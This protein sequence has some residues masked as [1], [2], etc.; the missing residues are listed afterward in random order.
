MRRRLA[1]LAAVP[2]LFAAACGSSGGD[3]SGTAAS[4]AASSASAAANGAPGSLTVA[5]KTGAKPTVTFTA[6]RPANTS[7]SKVLDEGKGGAVKMGD[8]VVANMTVYT[9]DGKTNA[10]GGSTYDNGAPEVV[11][12]TDQLPKVVRD[13]FVATKPGGRFYAVV[14]AD[15][16]TKEQLDE[17]KKQGAD[18]SVAQV[19]VVDVLGA[20]QAKTAS[21][22]DTGATVKGVQ[23]E[24]PGEGQA[25]K[26]TTKT[27]DK[28]STKLVAETV[29]KGTGPE[30]KSGEFIMVQ[31]VGKIWGTDS[32]FDSSWSR[33]GVPVLFQIGAGKVI[34]GWDEGLV[35]IPVGSRVLL[36]IPPDLGYGSA[37]QGDKIKG[38][39]TLV[40]AVD[41]L[42][43]F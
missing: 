13:G 28:A 4:P 37:G 31:Y 26:L 19:F 1:V 34:K 23:L 11:P 41:V 32:E 10:T 22:K 42:G 6:G 12:L 29:I 36:T 3:G 15:N 16:Y 30:V 7:T 18:T 14:A 43:A 33:G 20:T 40:F 8:N 21:G 17:A 27:S 25:P 9:W 39:D 35:G 24:N 38:T 5:G 2:L